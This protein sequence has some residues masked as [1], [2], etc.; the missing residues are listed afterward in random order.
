MRVRCQG[1]IWREELSI[2]LRESMQITRLFSA[3]EYVLLWNVAKTGG[4]NEVVTRLDKYQVHY[5]Y[6]SLAHGIL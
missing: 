1:G 2:K 5:T 4:F 3:S 6:V